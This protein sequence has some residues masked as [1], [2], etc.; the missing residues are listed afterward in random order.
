MLVAEAQQSHLIA[1]IAS[2][3]DI[4]HESRGKARSSA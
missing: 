3:V 1:G 2:A 4:V